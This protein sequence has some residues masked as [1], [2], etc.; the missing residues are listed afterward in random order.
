[1]T[2]NTVGTAVVR[3]AKRAVAKSKQAESATALIIASDVVRKNAESRMADI[4]AGIGFQLEAVNKGD[5]KLL[6]EQKRYRRMF[7]AAPGVKSLFGGADVP[8]L[9]GATDAYRKAWAGVKAEAQV[10]LS[11]ML[12]KDGMSR[13]TADATAKTQLETERKSLSRDY[14]I[15][16]EDAVRAEIS[17]PVQRAIFMLSH[18][19]KFNS[20]L[21]EGQAC[22]PWKD[23]TVERDDKSGAVTL[24]VPGHVVNLKT[25]EVKAL[26]TK[27]ETPGNQKGNGTA[28]DTVATAAKN[29]ADHYAGHLAKHAVDELLGDAQAV[30]ASI[31]ST[32]VPESIDL[33]TRARAFVSVE[34][35]LLSVA[36]HLSLTS[37]SLDAA[38]KYKG[39]AV[40]PAPKSEAQKAE[41]FA[42]Q[43]EAESK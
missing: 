25:G 35:A 20:T 9:V 32:T 1:M 18:G 34:R 28:G 37:E 21:P 33:A 29:L 22:I 3:Q 4:L 11:A 14:R 8:D 15:D 16:L 12:Q 40:K 10:R 41:E 19:F 43:L 6:D 24:I 39:A 2:T 17:N 42:S 7:P 27:A 38:R 31:L 26:P 23:A 13:K 36:K 30:L 5:E